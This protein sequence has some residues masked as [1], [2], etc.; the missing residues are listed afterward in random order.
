ML[1]LNSLGKRCKE[2]ENTLA[3]ASSRLTSKNAEIKSLDCLVHDRD[4]EIDRLVKIIEE[5]R[6]EP[7]TVVN[8]DEAEEWRLRFAELQDR[9]RRDIDNYENELHHKD[10]VVLGKSDHS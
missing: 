2:L 9:F 10:L 5:L 6:R 7:K 3:D 4:A 1:E 8:F